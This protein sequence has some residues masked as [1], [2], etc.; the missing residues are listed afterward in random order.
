MSISFRDAA[1]IGIT[2]A[3]ELGSSQVR[4]TNAHTT[5]VWW[6]TKVC[7]RRVMH[8]SPG[9]GSSW[10]VECGQG[11]TGFSTWWKRQSQ[12]AVHL[13]KSPV[14]FLGVEFTNIFCVRSATWI[15][16]HK[17]SLGWIG[18][19]ST[20]LHLWSVFVTRTLL[21]LRDAFAAD[22]D[23][24]QIV[25]E[26]NRSGWCNPGGRVLK[27]ELASCRGEFTACQS[28]SG[29]RTCTGNASPSGSS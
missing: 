23:T 29:S 28:H 3:A 5:E 26:L 13:L 15:W 24:G 22:R 1:R 4:R 21:A 2:A 9:E 12:M 10:S 25:S 20:K 7:N 17:C 16:R 27:A 6:P 19:T 11:K 14:E 18:D 8:R